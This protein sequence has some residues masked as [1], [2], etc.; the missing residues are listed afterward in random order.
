M[1]RVKRKEEGGRRKEEGERRRLLSTKI[2]IPRRTSRHW[3]VARSTWGRKVRESVRSEEEKE[4]GN[5]SRREREK[6]RTSHP[7][8]LTTT[9][10]ERR[11]APP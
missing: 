11:R 3:R 10:K 9:R 2:T 1:Q 7:T 4:A 5:E 8:R 6:D